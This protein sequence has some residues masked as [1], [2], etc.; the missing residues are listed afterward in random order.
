MRHYADAETASPILR[1]LA[2]CPAGDDLASPMGPI[3]GQIAVIPLV[4]HYADAETAS[5]VPSAD[6]LPA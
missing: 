1:A 6:A 5:S 4:R 3:A 2:R